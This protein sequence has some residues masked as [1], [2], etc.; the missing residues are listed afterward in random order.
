VCV[1]VCLFLSFSRWTTTHDRNRGRSQWYSSSLRTL[2]IYPLA[3]TSGRR[4]TF[5]HP[6]NWTCRYEYIRAKTEW[7]L[8]RVACGISRIYFHFLPRQL[9]FAFR[10]YFLRGRVVKIKVMMMIKRVNFSVLATTAT[11]LYLTIRHGYWGTNEF[12]VTRCSSSHVLFQSRFV[13]LTSRSQY[14]FDEF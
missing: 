7:L 14:G 3:G 9:L 11:K 2:N 5:H 13:T 12:L 10:S 4:S 8:S 1:C 6:R